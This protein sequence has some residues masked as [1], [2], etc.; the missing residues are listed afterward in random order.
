MG[1]SWLRWTIFPVRREIGVGRPLLQKEMIVDK[2]GSKRFSTIFNVSFSLCNLHPCSSAFWA[3]PFSLFVEAP[4]FFLHFYT[5]FLAI[6]LFQTP[7]PTLPFSTFFR[8]LPVWDSFT[9]ATSSGVPF[10]TI[11]P[12]LFPPSGPRSIM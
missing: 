9:S 2:K 4:F 1:A 6:H 11:V 10:A 3:E 12:P 8:N 7:A 5:A